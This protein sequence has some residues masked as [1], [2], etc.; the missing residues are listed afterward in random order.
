MSDFYEPEGLHVT[1]DRVV[2]TPNLP[3]P[4]EMPYS[5]VYFITIH[6]D[7]ERI[8]TIRGRKWV[9]T[10]SNGDVTAVEGEGVVGESPTL[11]PG[12]QFTYNSRHVLATPTGYAEGSYIG[13]DD[14]GRRVLTRIPRFELDA[15]TGPVDEGSWA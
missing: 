15:S 6:N 13:L 8:I 4:P 2:Y 10:D 11:S 3:A 12:E 14:T 7:S 1:V 9:V 5:F